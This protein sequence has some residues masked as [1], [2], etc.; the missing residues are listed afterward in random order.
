M[1]PKAKKD[2][3]ECSS[4]YDDS[5]IN[6]K[7]YEESIIDALATEKSLFGIHQRTQKFG[8]FQKFWA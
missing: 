5:P 3:K 6:N 8:V 7:K 1:Y 2:G 4:E